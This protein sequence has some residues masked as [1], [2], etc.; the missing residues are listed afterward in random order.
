MAKTKDGRLK[1]TP[2][3]M[4]EIS[5][6]L[7][8]GA[9]MKSTAGSVGIDYSTLKRWLAW[10]REGKEPFATLCAPLKKAR[11]RAIASAEQRIYEGKT[12]WQAAARWLE[13]I[14]PEQWRRLWTKHCGRLRSTDAHLRVSVRWLR[15]ECLD[16]E[17]FLSLAEANSVVDRWRR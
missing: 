8:A 2:K 6:H 3:L 5:R 9:S 10:E 15:D 14:D 17:L 16:G 1:C 11:Y 7:L 13:S 12:G 4:A